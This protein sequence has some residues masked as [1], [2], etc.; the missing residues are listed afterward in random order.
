[1]ADRIAANKRNALKYVLDDIGA[2]GTEE[3][4]TGKLDVDLDLCEFNNALIGASEKKNAGGPSVGA[5]L[6]ARA[7]ISNPQPN[8][9]IITLAWQGVRTTVKPVEACGSGSYGDDRKR[10]TV[11]FPLR[12]ATLTVT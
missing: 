2:A 6:G 1:M 10:R 5:M 3:D 8:V 9:Y 7:C 12:V 4:C 11:S